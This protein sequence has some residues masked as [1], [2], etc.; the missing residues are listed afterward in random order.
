MGIGCNIL[1]KSHVPAWKVELMENAKWTPLRPY[2]QN[3]THEEL[4]Q[5][6]AKEILACIDHPHKIKA[7][8]FIKSYLQDIVLDTAII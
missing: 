2:L 5:L 1:Y 3:H 6:T 7:A 4:A 8:L